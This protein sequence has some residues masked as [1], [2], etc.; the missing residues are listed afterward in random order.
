[1]KKLI[2]VLA[3]GMIAADSMGQTG[4]KTIALAPAPPQVKDMPA[5]P[6]PPSPQDVQ[7][8]PPPPPKPPLPPVV[9]TEKGYTILIQQT[10]EEPIILLTKNGITQKIRM[11]IWNAKPAYFENKYGQLPPPPPPVP[12]LPSLKE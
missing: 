6:P 7:F 11:H 10:K 12:P 9:V 5:P 2:I 3:V 4:K 8:A 1:M